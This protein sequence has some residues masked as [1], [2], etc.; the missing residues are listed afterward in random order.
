MFTYCGRQSPLLFIVLLFLLSSRDISAQA[1]PY[2]DLGIKKLPDTVLNRSALIVPDPFN[3][4]RA[5]RRLFPGKWYDLGTRSGYKDQIINWI[6]PTCK[7]AIY[8]DANMQDGDTVRFPYSDGVAT[9]LINVFS[10]TDS[11]GKRYKIMSF[12]HSAYDLDGIQ[13]GRFSGG[14]LGMAK[15]IR[16]D[17]G[18]QLQIFQ[19]A[20]GAYGSFSQAPAPTPILIGDRQYAYMIDHVNGGPGGPFWQDN[21]LIA[22]VRGSYRQILSVVGTSRTASTDGRSSWKCT[23]AV[24]PGEKHSFQDIV[25]VIKGHYWGADPEGLPAELNGKVK[26]NELGSFT[27]THTFSY[28]DKKGYQELRPAR[29]SIKR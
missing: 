4:N 6:C 13:S 3:A 20:I 19:P 21:F 11:S 29:V 8:A 25:F 16:I 24:V 23:Y 2:G 17:S 5:L 9:R 14:L 15:F 7:T 1:P 27:I 26:G 18:W 28:S 10:Y 22:E 12:N